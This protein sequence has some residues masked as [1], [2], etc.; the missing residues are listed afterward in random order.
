MIIERKKQEHL[1]KRS[2]HITKLLYKNRR[3][4]YST[5]SVLCSDTTYSPII[6]QNVGC[7]VNLS[8][9]IK[10]TFNHFEIDKQR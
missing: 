9:C 1:T 5:K 2:R 10:I 7:L 3:V 4:S 8:E 6:L